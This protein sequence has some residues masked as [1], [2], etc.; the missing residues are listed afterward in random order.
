M[1]ADE[2]NA[3]SDTWNTPAR[4]VELARTV[5]GGIDLDPASN[6]AAQAVV[7]A[8]RYYTAETDGLAQQWTGRVWMNPPYSKALIGP[9]VQKLISELIA[10]RCTEC[11]VLVNAR[12]GSAWYQNLARFFVRCDIRKR[13]MFWRP[14]KAPSAGRCDSTIFYFG[15]NARRFKATFRAVGVVTDP[16]PLS[17]TRQCAVCAGPVAAVRGDAVHCSNACRQRAYRARGRAA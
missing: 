14:D 6:D 2:P 10:E 12:P 1:T 17:V 13:I 3:A 8:A 16:P 4:F 7:G 15:P 11:V 5:M 9:F